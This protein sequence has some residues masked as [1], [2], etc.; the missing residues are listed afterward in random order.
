MGFE[1]FSLY[2][3]LNPEQLS[4]EQT[5]GLD[6]VQ[7]YVDL[8]NN[9]S[10]SLEEIAQIIGEDFPARLG[11]GPRGLQVTI[12]Q[13][14]HTFSDFSFSILSF[15]PDLISTSSVSIKFGFKGNYQ[16]DKFP[17]AKGTM[18]NLEI[19]L[20]YVIK[21]GKICG[22]TGNLKEKMEKKYGFFDS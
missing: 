7:R 12:M 14:H 22:G 1:R 9:P 4:D 17:D 15:N 19:D 8:W 13:R 3:P 11:N 21:D 5:Q 10:C 18:V 6:L 2:P 20:T 16:G